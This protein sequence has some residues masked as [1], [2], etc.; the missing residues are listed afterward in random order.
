MTRI[1]EKGVT[2]PSNKDTFS[3]RFFIFFQ[4]RCVY[5]CVCVA[6]MCDDALTVFFFSFPPPSTSFVPL[7]FSFFFLCFEE[8]FSLLPSLY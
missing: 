5:V 1:K 6:S 8:V 7:N 3:L 4:L 2:V